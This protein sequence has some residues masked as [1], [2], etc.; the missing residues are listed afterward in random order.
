MANDD[1]DQCVH[2]AEFIPGF[3]GRGGR[4]G[5]WP[6]GRADATVAELEKAKAELGVEN[7][8]DAGVVLPDPDEPFAA[9]DLTDL[10]D[11]LGVSRVNSTRVH[12][13]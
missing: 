12:A 6:S 1:T 11:L 7:P 2:L 3:G 4:R 13:R 8:L 5:R 9:F 10:A